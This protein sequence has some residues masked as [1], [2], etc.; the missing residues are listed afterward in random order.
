MSYVFFGRLEDNAFSHSLEC[1][2][3]SEL[4]LKVAAALYVLRTSVGYL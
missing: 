2:A 3:D 4:A 1:T